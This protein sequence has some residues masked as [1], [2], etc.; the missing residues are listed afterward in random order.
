MNLGDSWAGT[1]EGRAIAT[2]ADPWDAITIRKAAEAPVFAPAPRSALNFKP[3]HIAAA[4]L[5]LIA[6]L[7]MPKRKGK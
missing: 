4:A 2:Q 1:P 5:L 6:A 3:T 7:A